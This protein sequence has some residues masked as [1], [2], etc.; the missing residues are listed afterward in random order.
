MKLPV[1]YNIEEFGLF[2][3]DNEAV[4][5]FASSTDA[6]GELIANALNDA[7]ALRMK[8]EQYKSALEFYADPDDCA[9]ESCDDDMQNGLHRKYITATCH[10]REVARNAIKAKQ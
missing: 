6:D 3:D 5:L 1:R 10:P 9:W 2:D 4:I 8:L 7:E